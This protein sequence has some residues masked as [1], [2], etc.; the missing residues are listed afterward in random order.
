[1]TEEQEVLG[2][3]LLPPAP[4]CL[5]TLKGEK[6]QAFDSMTEHTIKKKRSSLI[7]NYLLEK[8]LCPKLMRWGLGKGSSAGL[9]VRRGPGFLTAGGLVKP[10][11]PTNPALFLC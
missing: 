8:A 10:Q 4:S 9:G 7:P 1:V 6:L 5:R 11:Q 3:L 2:P